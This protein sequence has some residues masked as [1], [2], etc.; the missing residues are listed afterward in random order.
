MLSLCFFFRFQISIVIYS[1]DEAGNGSRHFG[2]HYDHA[3]KLYSLQAKEL[4]TT[5]KGSDC[6]LYHVHFCLGG[7][8]LRIRAVQ[9]TL[10]GL[11]PPS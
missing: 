10:G 6:L 11:A 1:K 4:E 3:I 8:D 7:L 2:D 9:I 5:G